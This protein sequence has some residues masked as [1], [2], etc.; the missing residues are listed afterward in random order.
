MTV[1]HAIGAGVMCRCPQCRRGPL[2]AGFL[3][4]KEQ[5]EVCGFDMAAADTGDG[6]AVFVILIGGALVIGPA[7]YLQITQGWSP[8]ATMAFALPLT[9]MIC[10]GLLRPFKAVLIAL[11][12]HNRASQVR[13]TDLRP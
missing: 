10:L 11:Q 8:G 3:R 7:F 2:Y 1:L 4:L 9:L 6:P 12:V 13:N 5:C